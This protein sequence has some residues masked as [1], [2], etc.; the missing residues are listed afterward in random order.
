MNVSKSL[1]FLAL[2]GASNATL[3]ASAQGVPEPATFVKKAAQDGMTEVQAAKVALEKSQDPSIRSFAQRMVTDHGM[4][5]KELES[6]ARTK[7]LE[8]PKELDAE[9]KAMVDALSAKSGAEFDREYSQH[10]NMD[11][12]K[13]ISLFEAASKTSDGD[14]AAFARKTHS[15]TFRVDDPSTL[16]PPPLPPPYAEP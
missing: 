10:M 16:M 8:V 5:N 13:A 11:H 4:A 1:L 14:L 7:G 6:I 12:S 2:A 15:D 9:H 3:A